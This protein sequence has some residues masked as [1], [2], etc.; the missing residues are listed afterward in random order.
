MKSVKI[1]GARIV[2]TGAGRGIGEAAAIR[3]AREGAADVICLDINGT[4]A[5]ATADTCREAGVAAA[6]YVCDVADA[7]AV[8]DLAVQIEDE[9]GPVDIVI[10]NAGVGVGG[11]F[12]E[13]TDTDWDW[14]IGI[15]LNGVAY[16]CRAF[17]GPM[18][19][20]GRGH[21]VNVASG[22]AYMMSSNAHAYCSSKAGVV[23]LSR[24]LRS[25]WA[26]HG[27]GVSV[28]CPGV[29]KTPLYSTNTRMY[30][31]TE[32][33]LRRTEKVFERF[34]RSPDVVARAIVSAVQQN[35]E[36]V[37]VGIESAVLYRA[38]PFMP[39][40]VRALIT[41]HAQL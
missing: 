15:N 30:G 7:A 33:Q 28:I 34:G 5:A 13:Q 32:T 36:L 26:S 29:I 40:P 22:A 31:R 4:E 17:G 3:L 21:V 1:R 2:I 27:V 25:E 12:L 16:G 19:R 41:K 35:R 10:N 18:V 23:A 39:Q 11:P 14:L 24:C 6:A 37:P 38:L 20:R 9:R 8:R